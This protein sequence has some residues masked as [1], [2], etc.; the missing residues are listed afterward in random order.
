L[1]GRVYSDAARTVLLHTIIVALHSNTDYRYIYAAEGGRW[2]DLGSSLYSME[3]Y[4]L[5]VGDPEEGA[6]GPVAR[7]GPLLGVGMVGL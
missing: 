7:I 1:Y 6:S 3:A 4:D 2:Q 5:D